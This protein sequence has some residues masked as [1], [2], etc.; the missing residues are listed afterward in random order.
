LARA[1]A[2]AA[3]ASIGRRGQA[4]LRRLDRRDGGLALGRAGRAGSGRFGGE[5]FFDRP[6]G[7]GFMP[8]VRGPA[9]PRLI[10]IMW[11]GRACGTTARQHNNMATTPMCT[12]NDARFMQRP[13]GS[14]GPSRT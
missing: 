11:R 10:V 4:R 14:T 13:A 7:V 12:A 2:W 8:V 1:V 9:A 6:R 3:P 5:L